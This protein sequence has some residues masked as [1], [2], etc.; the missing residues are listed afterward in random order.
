MMIAIDNIM[1][2]YLHGIPVYINKETEYIFDPD[3]GC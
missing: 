3:T 2:Q 1:L